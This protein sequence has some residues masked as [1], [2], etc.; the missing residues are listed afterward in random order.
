MNVTSICFL[1]CSYSVLMQHF[2][3]TL[4]LLLLKKTWRGF[5]VRF[6]FQS[7]SRVFW[8]VILGL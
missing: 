3:E 1:L 8:I 6:F 2:A 4:G 7:R 5:V